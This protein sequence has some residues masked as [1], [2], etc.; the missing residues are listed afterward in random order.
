MSIQRFLIER[1]LRLQ[2]K[3]RLLRDPDIMVLRRV[4]EAQEPLVR[5]VPLEVRVTAVDMGGIACERL[6]PD[7]APGDRVIFYVHGGGWVAGNPKVYRPFLWRLAKGSG[8]A[9][10]TPDYR[11]APEHPFPAGLDDVR[12]AYGALL[13]QGFGSDQI[14]AGGTA[15]GAI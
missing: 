5:P 6:T 1:L 13:A 4:M 11:L 10:L 12:A 7:G 2:V 3:R 15:R 9:V 8:I 14:I